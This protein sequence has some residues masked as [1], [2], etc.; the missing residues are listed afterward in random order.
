MSAT[1]VTPTTE[2][3]VKLD[4]NEEKMNRMPSTDSRLWIGDRRLL[5]LEVV[6]VRVDGRASNTGSIAS[7]K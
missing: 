6:G 4:T 3:P 1:N 7:S 5:D 2:K